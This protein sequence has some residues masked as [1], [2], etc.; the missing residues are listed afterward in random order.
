[1]RVLYNP[2]VVVKK[3]L[4]P[5]KGADLLVQV[6]VLLLRRLLYDN[7]TMTATETTTTTTVRFEDDLYHCHCRCHINS[8][9]DSFC[10]HCSC[11]F[12]AAIQIQRLILIMTIIVIITI[13][14]II[15]NNE[16]AAQPL[17]SELVDR[18]SPEHGCVQ[19]G[20]PQAL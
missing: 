5:E 11:S 20:K 1:M 15:C 9:D 13:G 14:I 16:A 3:V 10:P 18:K 8:Y 19:G 2:Y 6:L 7:T 4:P 12:L 17:E